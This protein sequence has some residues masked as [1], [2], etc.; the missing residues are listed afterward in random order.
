MSSNPY[1]SPNERDQSRKS[2]TWLVVLIVVLAVSVPLVC[3]CGGVVAIGAV[4]FWSAKVQVEERTI[5][6]EALDAEKEAIEAQTEAMEESMRRETESSE[7]ETP[8]Q[9]GEGLDTHN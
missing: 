1:E 9:I 5:E 6:M 3:I 4:G 8:Q 7:F 2:S